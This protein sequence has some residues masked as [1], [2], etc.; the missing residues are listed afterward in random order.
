MEL[1]YVDDPRTS[2]TPHP[3]STGGSTGTAYNGEVQMGRI[4][5]AHSSCSLHRGHDQPFQR[6]YR[7]GGEIAEC[8]LV[9][10][11]KVKK[12]VTDEVT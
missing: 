5:T 4:R 3:T 10:Q 12:D 1:I 9:A 2:V 7:K 6:A 11:V 8:G